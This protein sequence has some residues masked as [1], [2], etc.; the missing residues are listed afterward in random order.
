VTGIVAQMLQVNPSLGPI[1]VRRLLRQTASQAH[2]PDTTRGWGIVNADAAVRAAEWNARR[3]P[4]STLQVSPP[5]RAVGHSSLVVPVSAPPH[6]A[7]LRV[8]LVTPLGRQVRHAERTAYPGPNRLALDVS[9]LPAGIYCY[10]V[11][12]DTGH[13]ATGT[14]TITE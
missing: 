1:E 5:Y 8:S 9:S 10:D 7:A 2:A 3:T 6:T 11:A 13:H 4:P 14:V 12:T